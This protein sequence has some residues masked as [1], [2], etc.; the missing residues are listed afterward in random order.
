MLR[1]DDLTRAVMSA[2]VS[3]RPNQRQANLLRVDQLNAALARR[4]LWLTR[5]MLRWDHDLCSGSESRQ[6]P[7]ALTFVFFYPTERISRF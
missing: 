7:T 6:P 4:T 3:W 2:C 5:C 1:G